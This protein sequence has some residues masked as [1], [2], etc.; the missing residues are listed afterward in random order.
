MNIALGADHRGSDVLHQVRALLESS[1][2]HDIVLTADCGGE[3]CDYTD[4]AWAVGQAVNSGRAH[5]GILI[6]GTG[7]GSSIAANKVDGVRAALVFDELGAATARRCIDSNVLCLSAD[8]LGPRALDRIVETFLATGFDG[9]R[10]VRRLAK[11][12][13]IESGADPTNMTEPAPPHATGSNGRKTK[14][15]LVKR[16]DHAS[17]N[18]IHLDNPNTSHRSPESATPQLSKLDAGS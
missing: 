14:K 5:A 17:P 6:C 2:E 8:M 13:V 18:G 4:M 3:V 7:L 10:H 1:A 12:R 9:G 16:S 11:L 15:P